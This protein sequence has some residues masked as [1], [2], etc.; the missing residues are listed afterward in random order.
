M[1][2]ESR[3]RAVF[4]DRDGTINIDDGYIATHEQFRLY[5]FAA[6]AIRR[7]NESGWRVIIITNQAGI[8]RGLYT[9]GFLAELHERMVAEL[10]SGG[11]LLDAIY[12]CPHYPAADAAGESDL[13]RDCECRKPKPGMI[14]QACDE[15]GLAPEECYV[16]GDRYRDLAAG[17][18]VGM[19]G[20]LVRTGYGEE[21]ISREFREWVRPPH[22][23]AG[24][25]LDAVE[26]ILSQE[27]QEQG[28]EVEQ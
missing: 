5:D 17:F 1:K 6:G 4:L 19:R 3:R 9:E 23:I 28:G 18:E 26:W 14:H 12:H 25:L 16:V 8:A 7:L 15:F 24:N 13:L 11:A 20:V 21:E 22:R 27:R 2:P 10:S